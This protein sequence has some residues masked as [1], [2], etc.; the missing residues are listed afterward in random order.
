MQL[1]TSAATNLHSASS[2]VQHTFPLNITF[3]GD[4]QERCT[5]KRALLASEF[6]HLF[7]SSLHHHP[8]APFEKKCLSLMDAGEC[9]AVS[10]WTQWQ[11]AGRKWSAAVIWSLYSVPFHSCPDKILCHVPQ[12]QCY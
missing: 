5:I 6:A 7:D 3:H 10:G 12:A 8:V 2:E 11:A 9:A 1:S 4:N